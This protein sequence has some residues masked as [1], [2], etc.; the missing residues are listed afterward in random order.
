LACEPLHPRGNVQRLIGSTI[1]GANARCSERA[2]DRAV[3]PELEAICVRATADAPPDRYAT[4]RALHDDLV[5]YLD[6]ERDLQVRAEIAQTW[7]ER[8]AA[9]AA[10]VRAGDP[11]PV[12]RS[13][14]LEQASR[15]LALDPDNPQARETILR[16]LLEPPSVVPP[17]ARLQ[18]QEAEREAERRAARGGVVGFAAWLLFV[19]G[20]LLLGVRD[21]ATMAALLAVTVGALVVSWI[22][23]RTR[24]PGR[25]TRPA[26][27]GLGMIG[28]SI[29]GRLF[30]A[31]ILVPGIAATTAA[32]FCMQTQGARRYAYL[33]VAVA[34]VVVPLTAEYFGW[35]APSYLF[36]GDRIIIAPHLAHLPQTETLAFLVLVTVAA[37]VV[38]PLLLARMRDGLREAQQDLAVHV[39]QMEQMLPRSARSDFDHT[40]ISK[41]VRRASG[42]LAV[43]ADGGD[44]DDDA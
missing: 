7:A 9:T 3:P 27:F 8:A 19:P 32:S 28:L 16:L 5:A 36:A 38:P 29:V 24:A 14:A 22:G 30:G 4:A 18:M 21:W 23:G 15:A 12:Q 11:D 26:A 40:T 42:E 43:V 1:R 35:L 37:I 6:G 17:N 13:E 10:S 44:D 2:P 41:R 20:V 39:W 33:A 25:W 34:V 31:L